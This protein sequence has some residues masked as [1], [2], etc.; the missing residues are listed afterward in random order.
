MSRIGR[1]ELTL[2]PRP[3]GVAISWDHFDDLDQAK[4]DAR[5]QPECEWVITDRDN[6]CAVIAQSVAA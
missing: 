6:H 2:F 5:T 4:A 3:G 1:Y